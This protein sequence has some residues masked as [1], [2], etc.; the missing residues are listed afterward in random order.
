MGSIVPT[1]RNG[2]RVFERQDGKVVQALKE[3]AW[4]LLDE[5][6]LAPPEVLEALAPLLDR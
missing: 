1:M 5:V 2:M 3:G 6:N 4:I